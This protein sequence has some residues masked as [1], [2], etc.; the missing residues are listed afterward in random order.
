MSK[1]GSEIQIALLSGG[2][3]RP[4]AFGLTSA[5]VR[6]GIRVDLIAGD[7]LKATDFPHA[8]DFL[9]VFNFREGPSPR[10]SMLAKVVRVVSYYAK[11][12]HYAWTAKPRIFHILWNNG[13]DTFDR[14]VLM[15]YYR[16]LGKRV[17]LTAHNVNAGRRDAK[18]TLWNRLT[19]RFQYALCHHIFVHTDKMKQ[20][21]TDG[22]GI[23]PD[24]VTVI[25]FGINDSV[26]NTSLSPAQAKARLGLQPGEKTLLFF[27]NIAPYK[28]LEYLIE[29]FRQIAAAKSGYR[30]IVAGRPKPRLETHWDEVRARIGNNPESQ[31]LLLKIEYVPDEETEIYFKAADVLVLPYTEIFQSGVL[32]LGYSFGLPALVS[33]VGSLRDDVL[34]GDTGFVFAPRD[35]EALARSIEMYFDSD[36]FRDLAVRRPAII[37][38]ASAAPSWD[39]VADATRRAYLE[40]LP[41]SASSTSSIA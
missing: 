26:P 10:A 2:W 11:L 6:D 4:Y 41:V 16:L 9:T 24:S 34:E 3:D 38:H 32:F 20:E 14:V 31:G 19:L 40:L 18:D 15:L 12:L 39:T 33:D 30:L 36:L 27:G 37:A 35:S 23:G 5:L 22:F 13:F 8:S 7:D 1:Y 25:P 29:A 21:L 17:V 28:G